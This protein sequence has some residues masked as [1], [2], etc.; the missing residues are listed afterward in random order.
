MHHFPWNEPDELACCGH[1]R[2]DGESGSGAL[3]CPTCAA[4]LEAEELFDETPGALEAAGAA[5]VDPVLNAGVPAPAADA[6]RVVYA[7][8]F[9]PEARLFARRRRAVRR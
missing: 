5:V 7:L 2:G 4:H 6:V 3:T 8:Y 1:R 9:P